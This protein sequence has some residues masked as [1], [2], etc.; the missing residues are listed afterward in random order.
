MPGGYGL[1]FR[2]LQLSFYRSTVSIFFKKKKLGYL[3]SYSLYS[4]L[5]STVKSRRLPLLHQHS[6]TDISCPLYATQATVFYVFPL[7][8]C[9]ALLIVFWEPLHQCFFFFVKCG[10]FYRVH[11]GAHFCQLVPLLT[12]STQKCSVYPP[13]SFTLLL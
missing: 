13:C 6:A 7:W 4:Y 3:V 11:Q 9:R 12:P 8:R 10:G 1:G 5:L 2:T